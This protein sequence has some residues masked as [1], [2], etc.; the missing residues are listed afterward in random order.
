MENKEQQAN[1]ISEDIST[2]AGEATFKGA[3]QRLKEAWPLAAIALFLLIYS[4]HKGLQG[5][6]TTT[7]TPQFGQ[8]TT[9]PGKGTW[10]S[11]PNVRLPDM[12][13]LA[14]SPELTRAFAASANGTMFFTN[15]GGYRWDLAGR[16]PISTDSFETVTAAGYTPDGREYVAIGVEESSRTAIYENIGNGQWEV[17]LQGDFGGVAGAS[18]DG[19]VLVGGGGLLI[20]RE[21]AEWKIKKIRGAEELTLFSVSRENEK[22]LAVGD[23]GFVALSRDGGTNWSTTSLGDQPFYA[24]AISNSNFVAGGSAG[25]LWIKKNSEAFARVKGLDKGISIFALNLSPGVALAGGEAK[26]GSPIV[27]TSTD[28]LSW[29]MEPIKSVVQGRVVSI[30]RLHSGWIAASL[31]GHIIK[32]EQREN[33]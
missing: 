24:C 12:Q 28:G 10:S 26:D 3:L 18:H 22:I 6:P 33:G 7:N 19:S 4:Y 14:V 31:D 9:G 25:G 17:T 27:L 15:D 11:S 5:E 16:L 21:G 8:I 1:T 2:G 23:K 30:S 29:T 32:R 20:L 13:T